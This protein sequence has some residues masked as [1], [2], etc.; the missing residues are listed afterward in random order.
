MA[1][2][3]G[4]H[5][6]PSRTRKLSPPAPMV[7]GT[8]VP[9]RV[10]RRRFRTNE[11]SPRAPLD[12]RPDGYGRQGVVTRCGRP[13]WRRCPLVARRIDRSGARW[14]SPGV[15]RGP[16]SGQVRR[17]TDV[18]PP[19][20][21]A[22]RMGLVAGAR[23]VP[24]AVDAAVDPTPEGSVGDPPAVTVALRRHRAVAVGRLLPP[25]SPG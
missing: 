17:A 16:G 12:S 3:E 20:V 24:V 11:G 13:V 23:M 19:V 14:Q 7:L 18:D 10:G 22:V 21:V 2:A 6:F 1:I 9:G 15:V 4:S 8:R 25:G 5:P